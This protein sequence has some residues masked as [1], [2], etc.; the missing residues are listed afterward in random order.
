MGILD[1]KLTPAELAAQ[2]MISTAKQTFDF[3]VR[4]FNNGSKNFWQNPTLT[5]EEL[6]LALGPDAKELFELHYKLSQLIYSIDP[7][8]ISNSLSIIGSFTMNDDGTVTILD[9][10]PPSQP[11]NLSATIVEEL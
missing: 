8:K 4:A 2:N 10:T 5:P 3:I 6:A 9:N 7:T 1:N 11:N